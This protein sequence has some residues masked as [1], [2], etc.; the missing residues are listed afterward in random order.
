MKTSIYRQH[1]LSVALSFRGKFTTEEF[2]TC[3]KV[4]FPKTWARLVRT[5]GSPGRNAG[6]YY[7]AASRIAHMLIVHA[8]RGRLERLGYVQ[9]SNK[10]GSPVVLQFRV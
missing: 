9:S 4:R 3:F 5:Y 7:T 1:V 8:N 6:H 10:W 2:I